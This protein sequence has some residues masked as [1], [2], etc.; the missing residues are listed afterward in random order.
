MKLNQVHSGLQHISFRQTIR[1]MF[2]VQEQVLKTIIFKPQAYL[3]LADMSFQTL[4]IEY[5]YPLQISCPCKNC[6]I[7]SAPCVFYSL[8]FLRDHHK[9]QLCISN[10]KYM[11]Q[12]LLLDL[13]GKERREEEWK[14]EGKEAS[15]NAKGVILVSCYSIA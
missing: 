9:S 6:Q 5:T 2:P 15:R 3:L 1:G 10:L 7:H 11:L 4:L 12:L 13:E 8:S 14:E